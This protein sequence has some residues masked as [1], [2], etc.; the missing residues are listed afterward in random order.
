MNTNIKAIRPYKVTYKIN[1]QKHLFYT[2]KVLTR[3]RAIEE[4]AYKEDTI[5]SIGG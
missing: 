3:L 4:T 5:A 2:G 1:I